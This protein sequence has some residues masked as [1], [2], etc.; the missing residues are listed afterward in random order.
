MPRASRYYTPG[1]I[2]HITHRC[3]KKEFLLKFKR[4][5]ELGLYWLFE[6]KKRFDFI[7]LNYIVTSNHI[8]L[9]AQEGSNQEIAKSMPLV[10]G[11]TAQDF[12]R[13][14]KRNG[15]FWADR[16]PATAIEC[17]KYLRQC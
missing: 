14:K 16:Y 10:A 13:G 15:A 9:L 2:W 6:A 7:I 17:G 8:H 3:H 1:L 11:R 4:D 5:R 12:N